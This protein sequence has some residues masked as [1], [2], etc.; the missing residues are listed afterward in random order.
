MK[1]LYEQTWFINSINWLREHSTFFEKYGWG[2]SKNMEDFVRNPFEVM[3]DTCFPFVIKNVKPFSLLLRCGFK[4]YMDTRQAEYYADIKSEFPNVDP[5]MCQM[6]YHK[7]EFKKGKQFFLGNDKFHYVDF[8][9]SEWVTKYPNAAFM[10]QILVSMKY[11][12]I[13]IL[14]ISMNIRYAKSKYFQF[15]LGWAPQWQNSGVDETK[16]AVMCGKI[17][18]SGYE[19]ELEWNPNSEIYG[20]WEGTA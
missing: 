10:F 2:K 12:V 9:V 6:T 17:R 20:Y 11:Y 5:V 8:I 14:F 13:P 16:C 1:P 19:K 3:R 18:L 7:H 15:G 4:P